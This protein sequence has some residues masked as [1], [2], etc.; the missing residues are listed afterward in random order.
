MR[1]YLACGDR[2]AFQHKFSHD[3]EILVGDQVHYTIMGLTERVPNQ[4]G[5]VGY[6][7]FKVKAR[8]HHSEHIVLIGDW[9]Y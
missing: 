7:I 1:S 5:N 3:G 6:G 9:E 2:K 8:V 4:L